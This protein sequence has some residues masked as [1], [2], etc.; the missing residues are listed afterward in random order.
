MT[1]QCAKKLRIIDVLNSQYVKEEGLN[2]NYLIV[3]DEK[4]FRVNIIGTLVG[5]RIEENEADFDD[6]TGMI[7]LKSFEERK[8]FENFKPGDLV[9]VIGKPREFNNKYLVPEIIKKTSMDWLLVRKK[10]LKNFKTKVSEVV[11]KKT[12]MNDLLDK[13]K[14]LDDG[15]G[16]LIEQLI[17]EDPEN[18][19]KIQYL[20]KEGE[21]FQPSQGKVK[22]LE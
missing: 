4:V 17:K 20:L 15:N 18:E 14:S 13:I 9:L 5:I 16:V 19:K 12:S 3:N 8:V 10:E 22:V 7:L 6:S 21:L 11:E 2:P 1:T